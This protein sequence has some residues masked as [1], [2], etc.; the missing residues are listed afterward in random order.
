M[1]KAHDKRFD[2]T[3]PGQRFLRLAGMSAQLAGQIAKDRVKRALGQQDPEAD[4]RALYRDIGLKLAT[5]LGE[6]K[7]AVMKV[8][9]IASQ[10]KDI[11]PDEVVSALESLQRSSP[12][13]PYPRIAEQIRQELGQPPERLFAHFDKHPYAA[14]SIGQVHRARTHDGQEVVVKVQYPGV[15]ACI[16]SDLKHLRMALKLS[17]LLRIDKAVIDRIFAEI[18]RSLE[19]ELDYRKEADNARLFAE[20]HRADDKI[21]IPA[22]IT[23]LSSQRVLTLEHLAGDAMSE[24]CAPRYPQ[25]TIDAIGHR[26]FAAL[27]AQI[28]A[29]GA[30][31]CDPHAGNFAFR[32]DGSVIIYD[33]GCV[34]KISPA[35]ID[36]MRQTARAA[37][38]QRYEHFDRIMIA[39]GVRNTRH[40]E[41]IDSDFYADWSRTIMLGFSATPHDFGQSNLH[42]RIIAQAKRHWK[43]WP[44]FQPSA[45]TLLVQRTI[46]GH[47]WNMRRMGVIAAF[48]PDLEA[49]LQLTAEKPV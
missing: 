23:E 8:G 22:V 10:F 2:A 45:D 9:Q 15:D 26:L 48:R 13:M 16:D 1:S 33:Y 14:A 7:G 3:R 5:T 21:L 25:A 40:T 42:E 46:S 17:G 37:L 41:R 49:S 27:G 6:M 34:K 39:M 30:V 38:D 47:Y 31:H 28:Y 18:K 24:V 20:F 44:A 35:V 12:A 43:Y 19:D 32:A 29:L 4:P 11:L 36:V